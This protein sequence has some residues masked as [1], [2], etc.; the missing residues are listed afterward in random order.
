MYNVLK[1]NEISAA[2][3][4]GADY[5]LVKEAA[6]PDAIVLR[7]FNMHEYEIPQSVLC[8]GRA[9]A[10][11]NNIPVDK[12]SEKGIVVFNTPGANANAVKELVICGLFL[13]GRK[14]TDGI[15]WAKSLKGKGAEVAKT[16][17]K[18]KSAFVG[19]EIEGK[20]LGVIGLGAIGAMVANAAVKLG[21][22]VLGY[23]PYISIDGAW[24]LDHH[25]NKET[26]I[27]E[28]FRKSD[29]ISL[30][31]PLTDGTRGLINKDS[32]AIMKDGCAVLNFARGE[33]AESADVI[34]AVKEG[35]LSR[36]VTDFPTDEMLC[37]ENIIAIPH[38]GASTPEAE[39]N[40]AVM[41]AR[42]MKDF[43]ENGNITN[44]VNMP[45]CKLPRQGKFRIT[46]FHKNVKNVLSSITSVIG[47]EGVNIANLMSQSKGEYAYLIL[48]LDEKISSSALEAVK[49]MES[50]I[51]V[52]TFD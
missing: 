19:C 45:A 30:H 47:N 12:C 51:K 22:K 29:F 50:V 13:A 32:I 28:I 34:E 2:A 3:D 7:S 8:V 23:D 4:F 1:L 42:Q 40:C 10:G 24:N 26:D 38:L 31:V 46:V 39:D 11:V 20:T 43:I 33:L 5:S 35:K 16:V 52:R 15:E 27:N 9:G 44:S 37:R 21:M 18:G 17:E 49:A 14:I 6:S 25:V 36:Y 41:V 48:D